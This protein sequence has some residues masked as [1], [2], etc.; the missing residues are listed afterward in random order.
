MGMR[1]TMVANAPLT[2]KGTKGNSDSHLDKPP[3]PTAY[4]PHPNAYHEDADQ[5]YLVPE[6]QTMDDPG[7]SAPKQRAA[8]RAKCRCCKICCLYC[9]CTDCVVTCS[10][11]CPCCC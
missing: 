9:C 10:P 3:W 8:K 5:Q 11:F 2:M 6:T 1:S 4:Q 7:A